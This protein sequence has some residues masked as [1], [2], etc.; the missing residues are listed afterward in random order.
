MGK[1]KTFVAGKKTKKWKRKPRGTNARQNQRIKKLEN[2]LYPA[3]E[4]KTI[5][6]QE[7]QIAV[8]TGG[9]SRYPMLQVVQGTGSDER[10]GDKITLQSMKGQIVLTKGD[11]DNLVRVILAATPS[12][13]QLTMEDVLQYDSFMDVNDLVFASPYRLKAS[14]DS[15]TYKILFDKTYNINDNFNSIVDTFTCNLKGIHRQLEFNSPLNTNPDN[16][17]VS[18][19]MISDSAGAS[20][21]TVS[22]NLRTKFYDL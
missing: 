14:S 11:D 21:P 15:K 8:S 5:D 4:Y 16:F 1:S 17:K 18:L 20:H 19:L 12:S 22:Y 6:K 10:I 7:S 2:I 13:S 9:V 3:I